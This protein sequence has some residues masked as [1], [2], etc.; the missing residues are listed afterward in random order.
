[1]YE[2]WQFLHVTAATVW[3]GGSVLFVFLSFRFSAARDNPIAGPATGLMAKTSVPVFAVASLSTL[4]TGLIMAFGW[5]GFEALWIKIGLGGVILSIVMGFG[6][7]R[8]HGAKLEAAMQ[9]RGPG[10]SYVQ[11]LI[12]QGNLVS[13]VELVILVFVIWAMVTKP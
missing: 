11:A 1:V 6:Y 3:I 9:E 10:D 8:P 13:V 5:V 7:H 4:V 2:F 12:R